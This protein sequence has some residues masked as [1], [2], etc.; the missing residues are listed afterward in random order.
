MGE[1]GDYVV[2]LG[3]FT[4]FSSIVASTKSLV[5]CEC[6]K[7]RVLRCERDN[8]YPL[9][10]NAMLNKSVLRKVLKGGKSLKSTRTQACT[11]RSSSHDL[12]DLWCTC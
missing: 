5:S 9:S 10:T 4:E 1:F 12:E 7:F 11:R 3:A 8:G 6:H 2:V